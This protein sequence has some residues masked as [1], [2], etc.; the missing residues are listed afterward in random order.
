MYGTIVE[1]RMKFCTELFKSI[2]DLFEGHTKRCIVGSSNI[3][4]YFGT[5]YVPFKMTLMGLFIQNSV[6]RGANVRMLLVFLKWY[7]HNEC[8]ISRMKAS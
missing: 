8:K 2:D 1:N 5:T 3:S 6:S 4:S 7:R